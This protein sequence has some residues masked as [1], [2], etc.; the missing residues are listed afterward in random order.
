M[1][2]VADKEIGDIVE[3]G[4]GEIPRRSSCNA[5]RLQPE[6]VWGEISGAWFF[7]QKMTVKVKYIAVVL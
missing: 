5:Q 1:P 2:E 3:D 4:E 6:D 7:A